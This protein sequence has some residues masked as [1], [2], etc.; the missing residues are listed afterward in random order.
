MEEANKGYNLKKV[1]VKICID[2]FNMF[3]NFHNLLRE[4]Q[5]QDNS[6]TYFNFQTA[7]T[8]PY[9]MNVYV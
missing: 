1:S 5:A 8:Y 4:N 2:L 9:L 7:T 6:N 3:D